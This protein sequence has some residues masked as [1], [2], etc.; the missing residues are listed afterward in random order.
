MG[1]VAGQDNDCTIQAQR[2]FD[3]LQI[4]R[5]EIMANG[6]SIIIFAPGY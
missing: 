1:M 4:N 3:I 5:S 2:Q 6:G